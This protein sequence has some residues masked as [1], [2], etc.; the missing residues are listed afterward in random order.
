METRALFDFVDIT[1]RIQEVVDGWP[2]GNGQIT[3]FTDCVSCSLIVNERE[4]GL[5]EDIRSTMRRLDTSTMHDRRALL[6]SSSVVLPVVD[7]RLH[8][9]DWQRL[10]LVELAEPGARKV[11]VQMVGE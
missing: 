10:L 5:L 9:G 8:L 4:S 3:V 11:V 6:G 2:A 1:D 7:G